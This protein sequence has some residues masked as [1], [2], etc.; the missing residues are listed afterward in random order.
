ML[1]FYILLLIGSSVLMA[2]SGSLL[3]ES[4]I[5]VAKAVNWREFVVGFFIMAF[6]TSLPNLF[7]GVTSALRGVPELSF[8]DVVGGNVVDLTLGMALGVLIGGGIIA[9]SRTVQSSAIFMMGIAIL[10]L[11]LILDG[12][13]SRVD[14]VILLITFLLYSLWLFSKEERFRKIYDGVE[15]ENK[16]FVIKSL[17][18]S[19]IGILLLILGSHGVVKSA[20]FFTETLGLPLGLIGILIVGLGNC[21]PEIYFTI[22]SA[23]KEQGWLILGNMIGGIIT[24]ASLVL[25]IVVLIHPIKIVDFSPYLLGRIFLI[26]STLFFLIFLRSGRKLTR[27]EALFLL[28]VYISFLLS[29]IFI[30]F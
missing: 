20:F 10:P 1:F 16:K 27:R 26:V 14:G 25:G 11:F 12:E 9:E 28:A 22:I 15:R 6:A 19:I 23:K 29:E 4:L 13:L 3:V 2:L 21:L 30:K 24:C 17:F 18:L 8:G 7:V 5:R